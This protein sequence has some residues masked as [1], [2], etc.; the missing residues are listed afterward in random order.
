VVDKNNIDKH[1]YTYSRGI[2][3]QETEKWG[4]N[5]AAQRYGEPESPNT[6]PKDTHAPQKLGD[7]NNL[8][9]P[10]YSNDT[11]NDW[12]RGFGKG[13]SESAEGR[14]NYGKSYRGK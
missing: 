6:R 10:K 9:G 4:R 12:R 3:A 8:Q 2:K 13:G 11:S 5:T 7:S 14:P 1:R